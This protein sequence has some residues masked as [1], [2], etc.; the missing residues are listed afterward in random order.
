MICTTTGPPPT[1]PSLQLLGHG[2]VRLA[3]G[4]LLD[5]LRGGEL[6]DL[7]GEL[8]LLSQPHLLERLGLDAVEVLAQAGELGIL[9]RDWGVSW[10]AW[11]QATPLTDLGE[12]HARLGDQAGLLLLGRRDLGDL[13][14]GLG[15]GSARLAY[16][17]L[18]WITSAFSC[19]AVSSWAIFSRV[20]LCVLS[21]MSVCWLRR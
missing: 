16:A 6:D 5:V 12:V 7:R 20:S 13:L 19:A 15:L 11:C 18:T 17:K 3:P 10:V 21:M 1:T 9:C 2:A 14:G 8:E 4:R